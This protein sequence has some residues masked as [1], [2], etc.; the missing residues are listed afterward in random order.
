MISDTEQH[1]LNSIEEGHMI[2]SK[3]YSLSLKTH[4]LLR[5]ENAFS[6]RAKMMNVIRELQ[7]MNYGLS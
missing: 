4:L 2:N 1:S 5:K 6:W 7:V 3:I